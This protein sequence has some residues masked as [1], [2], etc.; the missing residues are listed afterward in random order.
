[1]AISGDFYTLEEKLEKRCTFHD[2]QVTMTLNEFP[3][4]FRF[5]P[6]KP[7]LDQMAMDAQSGEI[8]NESMRSDAYL[9]MI[10][11]EDFTIKSSNNFVIENA[12]LSQ[13]ITMAKKLHYLWLQM[14]FEGAKTGKEWHRPERVDD[15]EDQPGDG[16][17]DEDGYGDPD[18]DAPD[19][20][21]MPD[22]EGDEH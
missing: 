6:S 15:D 13:L 19:L 7:A 3:V 4:V 5:H 22:D 21:D 16:G 10:F 14:Y 20:P 1:M 8:D 18:L 2:L 12:V 11:A 9:D 17:N